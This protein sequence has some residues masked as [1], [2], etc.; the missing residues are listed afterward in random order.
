MRSRPYEYVALTVPL[1]IHP[2][3][4][5]VSLIISFLTCGFSVIS[6]GHRLKSK[7]RIF[8]LSKETTTGFAQSNRSGI[9]VRPEP[10]R[11][12]KN[13]LRLGR[14]LTFPPLLCLLPLH[15]KLICCRRWPI[16]NGIKML[17]IHP[18]PPFE[19]TFVANI[20][21]SFEHPASRALWLTLVHS[22][23][24]ACPSYQ[25]MQFEQFSPLTPH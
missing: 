5:D 15:N 6:A 3:T 11:H 1:C 16:H 25:A 7:N 12:R 23:E 9:S 18:M 17:V 2:T 22:I 10:F 13:R 21:I 14:D 24:P 4:A 8:L 20:S 19:S